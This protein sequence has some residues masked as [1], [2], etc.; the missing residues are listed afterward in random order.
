MS[1][2]F[3]LGGSGRGKTFYAKRLMINEA[4]SHPDGKYIFIV[5]EQFTMQTQR[6]LV[7]LSPSMGI[8]NVEAQSFLRLAFRVFSEL[9]VGAAPVLDD[10]GK[11]MILKK[12]L[13]D[14]KDGLEYFGRNIGKNG[15]VLEIKSFLSELI[16]YGID[17]KK[18]SEMIDACGKKPMLKKK[19]KDMAV[20]Y[21]AFT[22][23]IEK[24]YITSEEVISVFSDVVRESALL[25]K[26]VICLDGF[27]GFTP[28]QYRLLEELLKTADKVY[29]TAAMDPGERMI[30]REPHVYGGAKHE[31]FYMSGKMISRL[32]SIAE[33]NNIEVL[34][35]IRVG[36]DDENTRFANSPSLSALEKN[37][38]R[39][40]V[41]KYGKKTEEISIHLLKQPGDEAAFIIRQISNLLRDKKCRYRDIAVIAGDLA[42]YG[43]L[44][45]GAMRKAGFSYFMDMKRNV[46]DN[47]FVETILA[48]YDIIIKDF[49]YKD[50]M[51]YVKSGFSD[52]S[53]EEA[54]ILD[55]F[56]LAS[57]IR[58]HKKWGAAWDCSHAFKKTSEEALKYVS[59]V[60]ESAREK[61]CRALM[62]LYEKTAG[63]RRGARQYAAALAEFFEDMNYY[64]KIMLMSDR[65]A[66]EG[67]AALAGEYQQIY[68]IALDVLDR[69][70]ELLG[71]EEMRP[72]EFKEI[73]EVGFSEARIGLIPPGVDC[74]VVG[75]MSRTRV[76]D[77]KYLFLIGAND[78]NIPKANKNGGVLSESERNFLADENF[79]MAPTSRELVYQE[80]FYLYL[81]MTKPSSHLYISYCEAG[82]D[83]RAQNPS[84]VVDRLKKMFPKLETVREDAYG[85]P[86]Q[87]LSNDLGVKYLISGLRNYNYEDGEWKE[88]YKFYMKDEGLRQE[89]ETLVDAS[90]YREGKSMIS[91]K[92]VR[93][94]Y[95]SAFKG[96]ISQLERYAACAFS[97]F[98]KYGLRLEERAEREVEF[99]DIGNVVHEAL[100]LYT[101]KL[102]K[103]GKQWPD[104]SEEEQRAQADICID[105]TVEK[106]KNS[107]M[108]ETKRTAY[109]ASRLKGLLAKTVWAITEQMKLGRFKTVESEFV[110]D[111]LENQKMEDDGDFMHLIGRID[112]ID[113]CLEDGRAYIKIVDYK[114]G[115]KD[116]SLSDF[117][118]GLQMQL[119]IYLRA[120]MDVAA[121]EKK[122]AIPAG[123]FYYNILD[124]IVDGKLSADDSKKEQ[125]KSLTM[126]GIS[127]EDD[128]VL[129]MLDLNFMTE[130]GKLPPDVSS[131]AARFS[132]DR[133]GNLKRQSAT[134]T[135]RD[136]DDLISFA[137]KSV[138]NIK[139]EI[140]SGRTDVN[141]YRKSG[142]GEESACGYC[143]YKDI[144]RF[145]VRIPG[146]SY[147]FLNKLTDD[148]VLEKIREKE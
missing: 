119:V 142:S 82:N 58:G 34:D 77:I 78:V 19:L 22:S 93:A 139:E 33:R 115:K 148:D 126:N 4:V 101:Q 116:F 48:V 31:L 91:K 21:F 71:D 110:F 11:T 123:V 23:Y 85:C 132:T 72:V 135:T 16:Q 140:M 118:Y 65:F 112:R 114:T 35:P 54:D 17:E 124:P 86:E 30:Y 84:Y 107:L 55:N 53:D 62:P 79:E 120:G 104:L 109:L 18:L 52:L 88:L 66:S 144:C 134:L 64:E 7:S 96:S 63:G 105:E 75:D 146:N 38:F 60:L 15:Y 76:S 67:N 39:Y 103:S 37:L 56:I 94:L 51:R 59:D 87:I 108:R 73:L 128:P 99:F 111:V 44:I 42:S 81:A 29:V 2:Q 125:L 141:P 12:V 117:Y 40:P 129:P 8:M 5:P 147:R 41:K 97:Y 70:V 92:A 24:R 57:G 26:S 27:T 143:P 138:L 69:L 130:S 10:M 14:E 46:L 32:R 80:Q 20:A 121:K 127:N 74:I 137:R 90:F 6:D 98:A 100:N 95:G 9:G 50:V 131:I 106:Y 83:G 113:E 1:L 133:D 68:K 136:F 13:M 122:I 36:M 49:D 43:A 145:D 25:R 102:I 45:D 61:I 47:P 3:I 28:L 89:L